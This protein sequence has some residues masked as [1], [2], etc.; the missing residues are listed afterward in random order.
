[1]IKFTI[2]TCTYNASKELSVTLD[3]IL[4]QTYEEVEHLII[5]GASQDDS[6][7]QIIHY[8]TRNDAIHNGHD[9]K[10]ISEPD[11]GL[12]DAMNKALINATG[13]F[14]L[15]LNAGDKLHSQETLTTLAEIGEQTDIL[16][17][18]I[19]GYTNIV[20]SQG[21]FVRKRRLEPPKEL[22]WTSFKQGMLVCHQAF[23]ASTKLTTKCCYDLNYRFSADFDWCIRLMKLAEQKRMPLINSNII[24]ADYLEGGM[25]TKNHRKSLLERF[26]IMR[27]HYGLF[28]TIWYHLYFIVRLIIKR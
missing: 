21:L 25:T 3:S 4:E 17:G 12:Y 5:D 15:F 24:V 28:S 23:I 1:M 16:P 20:D 7:N 2:A 11:N 8:K 27:I 18:V 22:N 9:V 19:Y 10:I 14:I 26:K 13:D 6:L